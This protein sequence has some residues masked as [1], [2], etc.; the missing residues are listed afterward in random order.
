MESIAY[1]IYAW[2]DQ[3]EILSLFKDYYH[4]R[5]STNQTTDIKTNQ[6]N[7]NWNSLIHNAYG[8]V[9]ISDVNSTSS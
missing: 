3:Y 8:S 6:E 9:S 2:E 5:V 7:I 1:K 4:N